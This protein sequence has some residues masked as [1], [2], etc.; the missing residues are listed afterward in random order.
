MTRTEQIQKAAMEH[1]SCKPQDKENAYLDFVRT[2]EWA[3]RTM[4]ERVCE[5]MEKQVYQDYAGAPLERFIPDYMVKKFL[6][7]IQK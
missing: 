3:D 2:A 7:D 6:A 5:W 4:I 1:A